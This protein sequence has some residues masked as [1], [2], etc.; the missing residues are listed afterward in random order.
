MQALHDYKTTLKPE[1]SIGLVPTMGA[2]HAGHLSLIQKSKAQNTHTIVSIFVNPTQFGPKEDF[3]QYPRDLQKDLFLC[4]T[5]GVDAVFAPTIAQMYPHSDTITLAP[6]KNL[7]YVFEGF[8]REGHFSGV[9]TIVLKLLHL[10]APNRAY[11]GQK[12]AQQLLLI[13]RLSHDLFLPVQIIPCPTQRDTDGLA[14]S[15]R[16]IYLSPQ[17][18]QIALK[19]PATLEAI[20][21]KIQEGQTQS[22]ALLAIGKQMLQGLDIEYFAICDHHLSPLD[23]I[24]KDGTIVLVAAKVGKTR[25]IDNLWI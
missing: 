15:S 16:N 10:I 6:P 14:L 25:L 20:K 24:Q 23:T 9:L 12:D 2:L 4:S 8:I 22:A 3:N 5:N 18:R 1:D 13:Q 7:G 21:Q 11:F 19:I 17:E